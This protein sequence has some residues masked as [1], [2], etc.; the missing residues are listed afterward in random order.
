MPAVQDGCNFP[1]DGAAFLLRRLQ[2]PG[3][4][5]FRKTA[6]AGA[7]SWLAFELFHRGQEHGFPGRAVPPQPVGA[8]GGVKLT[9][10]KPNIG[11]LTPTGRPFSAYWSWLVWVSGWL[12]PGLQRQGWSDG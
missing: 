8:L 6:D 12:S 7:R 9:R 4:P 1:R 5:S 3:Q 11:Y 10:T 2:L